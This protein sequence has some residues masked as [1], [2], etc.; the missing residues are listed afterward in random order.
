M[1]TLKHHNFFTDGQPEQSSFRKYLV[2]LEIR[3]GSPRARAIYETG[4]GTNWRFSTFKTPYLQNGVRH[5]Y[6]YY[7]YKTGPRLLLIT[8]R[9]LHARFRLVPKSMSLVDPEL[10]LNGLVFQSRPLKFE[11]R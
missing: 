7:Y 6:Y 11:R 10:T 9:K 4:V 8:N 2:H 1:H 5:Y 3:K